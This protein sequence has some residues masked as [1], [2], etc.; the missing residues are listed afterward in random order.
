M[1]GSTNSVDKIN[2]TKGRFAFQRLEAVSARFL[3]TPRDSTQFKIYESFLSYISHL[4]YPYSTW[5]WVTE[6]AESKT[7]DKG[8]YCILKFG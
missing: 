7:M 8:E 4:I 5:P 2:W 6:I 3:H 1:F